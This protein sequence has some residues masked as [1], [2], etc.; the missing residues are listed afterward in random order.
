MSYEII[1]MNDHGEILAM[2]TPREIIE[3]Q[4]RTCAIL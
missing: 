2:L 1:D 4:P 3:Q